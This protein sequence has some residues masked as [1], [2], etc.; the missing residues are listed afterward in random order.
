M[1]R[2]LIHKLIGL[3]LLAI[4]M[5]GCDT[6]SQEVAEVISPDGYPVATI[7]TD[8]TA[9]TFMEGDTIIFTV[10][11]DKQ[12]DTDVSFT[13]RITDGDATDD[14]FHVET[15]VIEA[16]TNSAEVMIVINQ[17]ADAEADETVTM[18]VGAFATATRYLIHPDSETEEISFTIENYASNVLE[19]V[20]SWD[21]DVEV[22]PNYPD[23]PDYRDIEHTGSEMDF[24]IFITDWSVYAATG[25]HPEEMEF[26][27][28]D[29]GTYIIW[30]E[31]WENYLLDSAWLAQGYGL[32]VD[33]I[34]VPIT[35]H[36]LQAGVQE[37]T[38]VQ[39]PSQVF[40]TNS[41][42]V[43]EGGDVVDTYVATVDVST[44][45][46]VTTYVISNNPDDILKKGLAPGA[47]LRFN[48]R[49]SII[50]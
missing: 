46:G 20:F 14:D 18:E 38:V 48:N 39:D 15:G 13:A 43:V 3:A 16:F 26:D 42:G 1:N 23:F 34:S 21:R 35:A 28:L 5:A 32:E 27:G 45:D 12:L 33:S 4:V 11:I 24:D 19:M 30:C 49:P 40:A 44:T 22:D 25:G 8:A 6:A 2:Y 10:S 17:D 41:P 47:K 37:V 50:K 29:D 7:S 36:F 31:L 9:T